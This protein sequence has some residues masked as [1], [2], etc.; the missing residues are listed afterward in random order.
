MRNQL[1]TSEVL[2]VPIARLDP[3]SALDETQRLYEDAAP[4]MLT[5]VNAHTLNLAASDSSYAELLRS[6]ELVLNDGKGVL[7]AGLI[8]GRRFPADLNGNFFTPLLLD[9]AAASGW[10][11]YILGARPGVAERVADVLK[12]KHPG[13]T[14]AG[15]MHGH[16]SA[17]DEDDVVTRIR[18]ANPGLLLVGMGNPL[19]ERFLARRLK[20]SGARVGLGVGAYLDFQVGEATRA[21]AWM[22]RI[23]IEW[24]HRLTQEP[25]RM[26]RRYLLGNP[27]FV[28]RV[29]RTRLRRGIRSKTS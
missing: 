13:L 26:W 28:W 29:L 25:R 20:E 4:A 15:T 11:I 27:L 17:D 14:I 5:Y 24:L 12:A 19:Q 23:G 16:F 6:A 3:G 2:G 10:S 1:S 22:N 9:H 18:A 7:L 8:L 21:P